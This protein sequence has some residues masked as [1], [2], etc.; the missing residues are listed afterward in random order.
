M[1]AGPPG[2]YVFSFDKVRVRTPR[3]HLPDDPLDYESPGI[4]ERSLLA[5][6]SHFNKAGEVAGMEIWVHER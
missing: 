2:L 4:V 5:P 1:Q 3:D 6:D